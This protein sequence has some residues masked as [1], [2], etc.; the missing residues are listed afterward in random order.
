MAPR[1]LFFRFVPVRPLSWAQMQFNRHV[2]IPGLSACQQLRNLWCVLAVLPSS[3]DPTS[4]LGDTSAATA[5]FGGTARRRRLR[6][7]R[8]R[9]LHD[10]TSLGVLLAFLLS[11]SCLWLVLPL[12]RHGCFP[13]TPIFPA[14]STLLRLLFLPQMVY[15]SRHTLP[16]FSVQRIPVDG[17]W[18]PRMHGCSAL[19]VCDGASGHSPT[20]LPHVCIIFLPHWIL[21]TL[22]FHLGDVFGSFLVFISVSHF[23]LPH[24]LLLSS[25]TC[26]LLLSTPPSPPRLLDERPPLLSAAVIVFELHHS[27]PIWFASVPVFA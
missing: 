1:Q 20:H 13:C 26:W 12:A 9:R 14:S 19:C 3:T 18:S 23:H 10:V 17:V 22:Q 15:P 25:T 2:A 16:L 11:G 27:D 4:I 7:R 6:L 21:S 24:S 8:R 5:D